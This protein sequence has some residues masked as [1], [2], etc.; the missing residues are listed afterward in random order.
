MSLFAAGL[1]MI[2][3]DALMSFWAQYSQA[4]AHLDANVGELYI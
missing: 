3:E 4:V 2:I 1:V